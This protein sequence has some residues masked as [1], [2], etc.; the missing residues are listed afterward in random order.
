MIFVLIFF[1][2]PVTVSGLLE[3]QR[4]P[5]LLLAEAAAAPHQALPQGWF[6]KFWHYLGTSEHSKPVLTTTVAR[7]LDTTDLNTAALPAKNKSTAEDP[8]DDLD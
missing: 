8:E 6:P 2:R 7:E 5:V 1:H 3:D 4:A